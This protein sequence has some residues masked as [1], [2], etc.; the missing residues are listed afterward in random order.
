MNFDEAREIVIRLLREKQK[1]KNSE[2]LRAIGGDATLLEQIRE[3]LLFY[4]LAEEKKGGLI[5][6]GEA[7]IIDGL[8]CPPPAERPA[9]GGGQDRHEEPKYPV[10]ISYSRQDE[11]EAAR[12]VSD[13]AVRGVRVFRDSREIPGGTSWRRVIVDAI[14]QCQVVITLVSKNSVASVQ[15]PKELSIASELRKPLLPIYLEDVPLRGE[16]RLL[17]TGLHFLKFTSGNRK[18]DVDLLLQAIMH[19]GVVARP[20]ARSRTPLIRDPAVV[21]GE[22]EGAWKR[23]SGRIAHYGRL[24]LHQDGHRL[25]GMINVTFVRDQETTDLEEILTGTTAESRIVLSGVSYRYIKQGKSTSYLLDKFVLALDEKG[26]VLSGDFY[27]K[28][29]LGEA[30][31]ERV[32]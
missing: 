18:D 12:L 7:A 26:S 13:L 28:K 19:H 20:A 21:D 30:R 32:R 15:V 6:S 25:T 8:N 29:G 1:A 10:F 9:D 14:E 31:F 17:L 16:L 11:S 27:S 22:W 2:L 3:D 4:D 23:F 24:I 5:Y